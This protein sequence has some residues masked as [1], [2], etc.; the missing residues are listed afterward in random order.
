MRIDQFC[1]FRVCVDVLEGA[2]AQVNSRHR[3][4]TDLAPA[5]DLEE[6]G[7]L[8]VRFLSR[9]LRV[10]ELIENGSRVMGAVL[11]GTFGY[12]PPYYFLTVRLRS[13]EQN[14]N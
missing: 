12:L 5:G 13:V 2:K 8:L 9:I 6:R 10:W 14:Q 1:V 11:F 7:V 3:R 4:A